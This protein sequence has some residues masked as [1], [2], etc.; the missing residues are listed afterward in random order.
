MKPCYKRSLKGW[1]SQRGDTS[2]SGWNGLHAIENWGNSLNLWADSGY[3]L[4][5]WDAYGLKKEMNAGDVSSVTPPD[6]NKAAQDA[7]D[8]QT[9]DRKK[10]LAT[11]GQTQYA[12][13]GAILLGDN[14]NT[15]N[16]G[17]L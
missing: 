11:G 15:I 14:I 16:L 3:S 5:S 8:A 17:G 13:A 10:L 2:F 6:P 12:G 4:S 1:R 9:A 7:K